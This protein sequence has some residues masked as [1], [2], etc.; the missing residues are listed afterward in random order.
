MLVYYFFAA[1]QLWF[2]FLS[3]KS[4][5]RF[6]RYVR[7]EVEKPRP[8]FQPYASVF[9]PCRGAEDGLRENLTAICEQDYP[10]YEVIF[11]VDNANDPAREI[12]SSVTGEVPSRIVVA[13]SAVDSG[14][15]V[16]NLR[17]AV[18][19]ADP[20]SEV[21]VF[22]DTDARPA[23]DWLSALIAPLANAELGAATGYRWFIPGSGG[24]ATQLRSVWNASITSALGDDQRRNFCW[25]GSTAIRRS[26]F[27]ELHAHE[28]WRGT[29]S[30]DFTLTRVL[31]E[32]NRP[33][34]FVPK[35]LVASVG[36]CDFKELIEFT[37]R[38]LKI[39]RV[40]AA[41]LW[42]PLLLGSLLFCG[43]FFGG[44]LLILERAARGVSFGLALIL[45]TLI[46]LLGAVKSYIRLK[47][48]MIPLVA[49]RK[50]LAK[51]LP[52]HLV[53]WPFASALYLANAITAGFS[54][55]IRWRGI[56]YELK[57][58]TEAVIIPRDNA[59]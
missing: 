36:D 20:A 1:L 52:A 37:N 40:Y 2:G 10:V 13:G 43:M 42:K 32:A 29:V 28:R 14:Q 59:Q 56:T 26:T 5:F 57:S 30:D 39:T 18:T 49:Y 9:V 35:C 24:L 7:S 6:A 47:T 41:H 58:A 3:L 15:K 22:V 12:I 44:I 33:I 25:G 51:S 31:Q 23:S 8:Q 17:V 50:Q 19:E 54:R 48:V 4:G 34:H 21:F 16:H 38:Q 27:E 46:Y 53:L 11:V 55:T 45:V